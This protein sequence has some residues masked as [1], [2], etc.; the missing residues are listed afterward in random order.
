MLYGS[1]DTSKAILIKKKASFYELYD[2]YMIKANNDKADPVVSMK[3]YQGNILCVV[4]VASNWGFAKSN[5]TQLTK[6]YDEFQPHLKV[7][8]FPCNQFAGQEPGTPEEILA[9]AKRYNAADEKF[10]FFE[11]GHVN[12]K[13][14]RDVYTW[15]KHKLPNEDEANSGGSAGG[16]VR[17]N[18]VIFLLDH[19]G[20]PIKRWYPSQTP[21]DNLKPY[22]EDLIAKKKATA[23]TTGEGEG[24]S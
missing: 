13:Q 10:D 16:E 8:A 9:F 20:N 12:G 22:L 19:E 15:L 2:R 7:L 21:Y 11:K 14:T 6:L 17:W 5:Y 4:N 18:Y 1:N 3:S 23:A 24:S